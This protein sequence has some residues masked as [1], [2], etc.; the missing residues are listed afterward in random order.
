MMLTRR[1][2]LIVSA[3]SGT[4]T[5]DTTVAYSKYVPSGSTKSAKLNYIGGKTVVMNQ[6]AVS[7]TRES[8]ILSGMTY[9]NNN[10]GTFTINGTANATDF[11]T[12]C[13]NANV[14]VANHKYLIC[15]C[16]TTG[17]GRYWLGFGGNYAD[18]DGNGGIIT[19]TSRPNLSVVFKYVSGASFNNV[20]FKP[21]I[22]DLT[23]M[24]GAGN[25]P[26]TVAQFK[27]IF[28]DDYYAYNVGNLLSAKVDNIVTKKADTT[29]IATFTIPS[30]IRA[31]TGYG[32]SA[33]TAY[34]EVNFETKKYIQRVSSRAYQ[35]GDENDNT[36]VTDKTTTYYALSA[37]I[38]TDISA[39]LSEDNYIQVEA[40]G[41]I[42]FEQVDDTMLPIPNSET[43]KIRG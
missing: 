37:P 34:N 23:Q 22:F 12:I 2:A 39:Y 38:E 24:F 17:T 21:Q 43:F 31:L 20:I 28:P 41:T 35:S 42:T 33:G 19:N 27:A 29:T 30:Q 9:T 25:E 26:S 15:G 5:T 7:P 13:V 40:G 32:W 11:Y 3:T 8:E 6:L 14:P 18:D 1:R 36:V 4:P 16:P 10:N